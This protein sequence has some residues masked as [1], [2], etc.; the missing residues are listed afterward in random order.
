MILGSHVIFG[1]YG[2]WLPNDPRGSWSDFVGSWELFRYGPATKTDVTHSVAHAEHDIQQRLAAKKAL[3]YPP[4]QF[5][6]IVQKRVWLTPNLFATSCTCAAGSGPSSSSPARTWLY[7]V[8]SFRF[9][10]SVRPSR[11][12]GRC[13]P[14]PRFQYGLRTSCVVRFTSLSARAYGPA[15]GMSRMLRTSTTS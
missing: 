12:R 15:A 11:F 3:K 1:T 2:F 5:T 8:S 6:G 9:Q 10:S 13:L 4:V 7:A 14:G